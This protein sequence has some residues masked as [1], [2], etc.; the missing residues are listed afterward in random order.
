VEPE[1]PAIRDAFRL[2]PVGPDGVE[3]EPPVKPAQARSRRAIISILTASGFCLALWSFR[4]LSFPVLLPLVAGILA[5]VCGILASLNRPD[6]GA[7][8]WVVVSLVI[9]VALCGSDIPFRIAVWASAPSLKREAQA[10]L[11]H[12][13]L[14][15]GDHPDIRGY[16]GVLPMAGVELG[17][18]QYRVDQSVV[19]FTF[20]KDQFAMGRRGLFY[21][22]H[23]LP[24]GNPTDWYAPHHLFGPWYSWR[25]TGW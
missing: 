8:L 17:E 18:T 20:E 15:P 3:L 19:I 6:V 13:I 1:L 22:E 9:C 2:Q 23:P 10:L 7:F 4:M 5:W 21:S 11:S 24:E 16:F 12:Q 25:Y 14:R